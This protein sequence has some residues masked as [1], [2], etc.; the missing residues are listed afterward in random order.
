MRQLT[1]LALFLITLANS[2]G[3]FVP[4]NGP[5]SNGSYTYLWARNDTAFA[6]RLENLWRTIDGGQTWTVLLNKGLPEN[7]DPRAITVARDIVFVGTNDDARVYTSSDWGETWNSEI[8][9]ATALW[10]PTHA[11]SD[12]EHVLL[13][14]TTFEPHYFDF[15]QKKWVSSSLSGVTHAL[16][17]QEDGSLIANVGSV[18]KG[19]THISNDQGK[20]WT[21]IKDEPK[22][23]SVGISGRTFDIIKTGNRLVAITNLNGYNPYYSDDNGASWVEASGAKAFGMLYYGRKFEKLSDGTL[24]LN[25]VGVLTISKDSG[26]TWSSEDKTLG[27]DFRIWKNNEILS[28]SGT[29]T[30]GGSG[31]CSSFEF[32]S[33]GINL[34]V[35][36]NN[37]V[38]FT[39]RGANYWHSYDGSTWSKD[40]VTN[41]IQLASMGEAYNTALVDDSLFVCSSNGLIG[42][43]N[44]GF[45]SYYN[46]VFQNKRIGAFNKLGSVYA[47]GTHEIRGN[48]EP[49]IFISTDDK[50]TWTKASFTNRIGLG[51][52]G[53]ANYVERF[54]EHNGNMYADMHGGF[55]RST[56]QGK[57]WEWLGGT[58]KGNIVSTGSVL[59]RH[60]DNGFTFGDYKSIDISE[61]N[62]TTWKSILEGIPGYSGQN[63]FDNYGN[64]FLAEG[65]I[66]L[67]VFDGGRRLVQLDVTNKKWIETDKNSSLPP[68]GELNTLIEYDGKL[69]ADLQQRGVWKLDGTASVAQ[70]TLQTIAVYPNP[71][72]G[73]YHFDVDIKSPHLFNAQ[74]TKIHAFSYSN[75]LLDISHLESGLYVLEGISGGTVYR[76]KIIKE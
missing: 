1:T 35:Y 61:D 27:L 39:S 2:F 73:M 74:G 17:F 52:V 32:V 13:G 70:H 7:V 42:G 18:S 72:N 26:A 55:A 68:T 76:I 65:T 49:S 33:N 3:Q 40:S 20:S 41:Y 71:S 11:T 64:V 37:L 29:I 15:D 22:I 19:F 10:V 25:N 45:R 47:V 66:Y 43:D 28:S 34:H 36:N 54:F 63:N 60:R 38:T 16:R 30:D 12:G 24:L 5:I 53:T 69:Y 48:V 6:A 14:G 46:S 50:K 8:D 9:G 75:R 57:T 4:T 21:Q 44:K 51:P 59:I 56:D 67:E 58:N 31:V 62:G 23:P